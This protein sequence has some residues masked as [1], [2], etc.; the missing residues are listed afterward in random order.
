MMDIDGLAQAL[1]GSKRAETQ[2]VSTDG[3][4]RTYT[5]VATS[6]SADGTVMIDLGGDVTLPDDLYDSDGNVVAEWDGVGVEM[7]TSPQVSAGDD[8][9][10]TLMG[11]SATKMPM[12]TSSAGS[13][14]RQNAA[15][16]AAKTV[17]DAAQAVAEAVNQ[18]FWHDTNGAHVT[19]ATQD[20]WEQEQSGPNSLW[21]A[22]GMLFRDGLNNLLTLTT[23]NGARALTIWDGLGN[24]AGNITALFGAFSR[25]GYEPTSKTS[26]TYFDSSGYQIKSRQSASPFKLYD[27]AGLVATDGYV[28]DNTGLGT[29]ADWTYVLKFAPPAGTDIEVYHV[30]RQSGSAKYLM[31]TFTAGTTGTISV[32][33][34]AYTYDGDVTV[35]YVHNASYVDDTN[36]AF[37]YSM[38][39]DA[40]HPYMHIGY[41]DKAQPRAGNTISVGNGLLAKTD[42][43][44]I[45]GRYNDNDPAH[46]VEVG[47]GT[48][49]R[50][51][52]NAFAVG[53]D[54]TVE[55]ADV[56]ASGNVEG[57]T[58]NGL[59]YPAPC[60]T[61]TGTNSTATASASGWQLTWFNTVVSSAG[62]TSD[63]FTNSNGVLT[64]QRDCVL[65]I[66]GAMNWY[67][68]IAGLRGFGIFE[69]ITAGSGTEHSAFQSFA[70]NLTGNRKS[71]VF[72]PKLFALSAG[73]SLTFGRYQQA[74]AVYRNG[75]NFS[76]LTVKVVG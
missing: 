41:I 24:T 50:A 63:Y 3:T 39:R 35:E 47:N 74:N 65:E 40:S 37:G 7:P 8:V 51:R 59:P 29:Y 15:I 49:D 36:A 44:A 30:P 72:P 33:N 28:L 20:E 70:A 43:Q 26:A 4:T 55:C 18:H 57:A 53:W 32:G 75:T 6:D 48:R 12:V 22:L 19:M 17:A 46:A 23:E 5:G 52:S 64:A 56:T 13:G 58:V 27:V 16:T 45:F 2:E 21:N 66:S 34:G 11:G 38:Y 14:D 42:G 68:A 67:D 9:I 1:F 69:G 62:T 10:V 76:W 71:V 54:G 25:I 31:G 61:Y 73:D 60:G